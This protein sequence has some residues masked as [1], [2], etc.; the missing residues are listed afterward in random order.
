MPYDYYWRELALFLWVSLRFFSPRQKSFFHILKFGNHRLQRGTWES[1][2]LLQDVG[3]FLSPS[4][5]EGFSLGITNPLLGG[6]SHPKNSQCEP[7]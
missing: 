2:P 3:P 4:L 1:V 6:R 5:G 7:L